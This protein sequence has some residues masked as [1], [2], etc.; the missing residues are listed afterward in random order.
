MTALTMNLI[1][2]HEGMLL[3]P[4][5]FQQADMRVDRATTYYM[6]HV[7]PFFWGVISL[8]IDKGLLTSGTFRPIELEAI[9]PDGLIVFGLPETTTPLEVNLSSFQNDLQASPLYVYLCIPELENGTTNLEGKFPR[10]LSSLSTR[11]SD[12]NTGEQTIDIPRL[13]PN[14]CLQV[15]SEPPPHFVSLPLAQVTYDSKS[16]SL[17][18]FLPPLV[19]ISA[20]TDIEQDCSKLVERLRQKLGYLQQKVQTV[21]D[22]TSKNPFFI[23]LEAIRLKIIAGLL[24][25]EATL[26]FGKVHP[27]FVYRELCALAGQISGI[28]FG[29][30]PPRFDPYD[31]LNIKKTFSLI[32]EYIARVLDEIEESYSTISFSL[33][34][35]VFS[36]QL[37]S[38][39]VGDSLV[40]SAQASSTMTMPDL[41]NWINNCVIVSDKYVTVAKD[42]R[43]L[44]AA[45]TP[46]S[47]V[48]TMNLIGT[49]GAQ[50]FVVDVDPR[51]IDSKGV[52][53]IFNVADNDMTRPVDIILY[54]PKEIVMKNEN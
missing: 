30:L 23:R 22:V 28:R 27:V 50:L 46:V 4:Q 42:N 14:L 49:S 51:Y 16:Y 19:E 36:L 17:T 32:I 38:S 25:F 24:P 20:I 8:K 18:N 40:L 3:M 31:H 33:T 34:N 11:V 44:G 5:H 53:C 52:L 43:V 54:N 35:R 41:L 45:R 10:Y 2:W 48:P 9:M 13:I 37:E 21:K 47:E 26:G 7:F 6:S 12:I 29:E 15:G 39:W 1:Q